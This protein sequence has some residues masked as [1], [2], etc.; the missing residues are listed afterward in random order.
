MVLCASSEDG[1][2]VKI[3]EPPAGAKNGDRV[4]F[5]GIENG[6]P[7]SPSQMKKEENIRE[8]SSFHEDRRSRGSLLW[9]EWH[10]HKRPSP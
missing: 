8:I 6:E 7:A 4:V 9:R 3:L 5:N 10:D 1:S 2:E